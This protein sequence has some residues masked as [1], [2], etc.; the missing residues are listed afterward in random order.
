MGGFHGYQLADDNF[1]KNNLAI[2]Y[3]TGVQSPQG[4]DGTFFIQFSGGLKY[5]FGRQKK[6]RDF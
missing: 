6:K 5:Y 4:I 2:S 1:A 3:G